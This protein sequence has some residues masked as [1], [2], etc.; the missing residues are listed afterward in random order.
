MKHDLVYSG[1]QTGP[2]VYLLTGQWPQSQNQ[3][4]A[5]MI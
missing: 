2:K 3:D 5:E 4:D 1:P